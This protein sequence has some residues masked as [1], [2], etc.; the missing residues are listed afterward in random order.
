MRAI[1]SPRHR[2]RLAAA[3]E[4]A[5]Q[6]AE[7]HRRPALSSAVPVRRAAVRAARSD[8]L[9]LAERLRQ[10]RPVD[11]AGMRLAREILTDGAGPLYIGNGDTVLLREW[12]RRALR[13]LDGD[14]RSR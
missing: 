8:L 6:R 13:T 7:R 2:A 5:V 14:G 10:P 9:D 11:P 3:L 12:A 1:D 4:D